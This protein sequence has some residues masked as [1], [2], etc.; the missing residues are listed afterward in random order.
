[1]TVSASTRESPWRARQLGNYAGKFL[2]A[3]AAC[4]EKRY[5]SIG[6]GWDYRFQGKAVVGSAL[7]YRK[8]VIHAAF[9]RM[10]A[11][12]RAGRISGLSRRRGYRI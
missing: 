6:H 10:D 3:C 8:T 11:G 1:M 12:E 9:F 5:E 2:E 7:A 4:E